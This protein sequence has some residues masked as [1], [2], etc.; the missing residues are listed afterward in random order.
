MIAATSQM[1]RADGRVHEDLRISLVLSVSYF[2]ALLAA[3]PHGLM[4]AAITTACVQ[5]T[6]AVFIAIYGFRSPSK[7]VGLQ[8]EKETV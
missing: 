5:L 2:V 4:A 3:L 8:L 1:L 6:A 7:S